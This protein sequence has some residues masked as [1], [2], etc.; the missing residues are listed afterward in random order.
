VKPED[1]RKPHKKALL[2]TALAVLGLAPAALAQQFLFNQAN[3]PTGLSPHQVVAADFNKNGQPDLAV[4]DEADNTVS[5]LLATPSGT[6][7]PK[8]AYATGNGPFAVAT[9]D[10]NG[11]G[12]PD[13]AVTNLFDDT[14]TILLGSASGTFTAG[15]VPAVG[16]EPV[17]VAT[18]D[19]NKD[20]K[21]DLAVVNLGAN[22]VS[23]L[24]GNGDG[25]FQTQTTFATGATPRSVAAGDF[26]G[27]GNLDLAITNSGANS[28]TILL[29][30]GTGS[31]T[32]A[33]SP[34]TASLPSW[35]AVGDFNGDGFLDLAVT[36]EDAAT[37]SV[38]LGNGN[39]TFQA[40]VDNAVGADPTFV[41]VSDFNGDGHLDLA[42]VNDDSNTVSVLLGNGNG[43]FQTH[44]DFG[45]A[46][47]PITLAAADFNGD[48]KLDLAV[49]N[50]LSDTISVLLG[51][52]D[53]TFGERITTGV[54]LGPAA[55]TTGEF[56][57]DQLLDVAVANSSAS[58]I[59][60]LLGN[61]SGGFTTGS[62]PATGAGPTGVASADFNSDGKADLVTANVTG[63][64]VSVLLG[65]GDGTFG[66]HNDF[67]TG[68]GPAAVAY[69]VFTSNGIQD[70]VTA[71]STAK[72]VSVLLGNGDGTF[73]KDTDFT[74][75]STPVAVSVADLNGDGNL[76][77][78]V[79]DFG[80]NQVSILLGTGTG[81]FGTQTTFTTGF[82]PSGIALGD[83]NG[84]GKLDIATAN[85]TSVSILLGN[86]DGTFQ[87]HQDFAAG[88]GDPDCVGSLLQ[89]LNGI[90]VGD[91]NG[92][93]KLDVVVTSNVGNV[94]QGLASVLLG[95]GNGTLQPQVQYSTGIEP[96]AVAAGSFTTTSGL[97]FVTVNQASDSISLFLNDPV[98]ALFP[99]SINFG[100]VNVGSTGGPI[101]V[102]VTNPGDAS[103]TISNV[104]AA[105]PFSQTSNC[106]TTLSPGASCTASVS[107]TPTG[108]G[109]SSGAL[110]LVDTAVTTP[111]AAAL[112]G[113]G[114]GTVPA[115]TLTP[116]SLNFGSVTI[117]TTSPSQ[118]VTLQNTG[119]ATLNITS[120]AA[121]SSY[122]ETST[123]SSTLAAGQSCAISVTFSPL[124]TGTITGAITITDNALNSPQTVGLTGTGTGPIATLSASS[125]N[126][127]TVV[128][129]TTSPSQMV[130][131]TNTGNTKLTISSI[132]L[133]GSAY[134]ETNNCTATLS[135]GSN[136][137]FT[138]TFKP[139]S[140]GTLTGT[141]TITDNASNS[142]QVISMT[143][144]GTEV[145]FSPS[146]LN[147]GTIAVGSSSAPQT[148]TLTNT[149][150]KNGLSITSIG[151]T[152]ANTN[153]FSETNTC[154]SSLPAGGSCT[155]TA[156]FTPLADG[157]LSAS[158]SVTDNGGGSPQ[159][160]PLAGTGSGTAPVIT[161]SP[162]SLNFGNVVV[163]TTS[164]AQTVTVTNS[165]NGA[166]SITSI[167]A[168]TNYGQTNTCGSSLGAGLNCTISV[169]FTPGASGTLNG[170]LTITDNAN[171]SP[172]TV[173]LT[174]VGTQPVVSLS[175]TSLNFG[176][177][178]VGTTSA[179]QTV[180]LT[181]TGNATLN[182]TSLTASASYGETNTCGS[183]VLAGGNCTISV[184]FTPSGSGTITGT[185][186]V[187]DNAPGSPQTVSL[188]GIGTT[189]PAVQLSPAS[190][191]FSNVSVGTTSAAQTV[192]LTNT[193]NATLTITSIVASTN[194]AQAN[195][196]GSSVLAGT[197]C[198][199]SVTFTPP[200]AGTFSGTVT[201]TDNAANSPQ[202]VTLTGT[203]VGGT[204]A[205]SLSPTSL[206]F[207][208]QVIN[209]T[210]SQQTV[211]LT[212]TGTGNLTITSVTISA[213]YV[214]TNKCPI[215]P[216]F[217]A[218]GANCTI[219]A[220]FKPTSSGTKTGTV[221]ITDN[222]AGSPH[223]VSLTGV[224]TVVSFS[225]A[226]LNFGTVTVG[227][228]SAP[229][230]VTLT[231]N[232]SGQALSVTDVALTG[233][234]PGDFSQT[235][236]CSSV[237]AK[238]TCTITVTFTPTATGARS[239]N[240]QV[241]DNGGG[242]PQLVPLSGTGQ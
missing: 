11:D 209:T 48:G 198:T 23:I 19:F 140:V 181:N 116:G 112:T 89:C 206:T 237:P 239:A 227:T 186:S 169:T 122:A 197:N 164:P 192:T 177:V 199:I 92:D 25:T 132:K 165:G 120:I 134:T 95:D 46:D 96:S 202:Q 163:G 176:S 224:G 156:T 135:P 3:F 166:L 152:G 70:L 24:L 37:V 172:Q 61:G 34:A 67:A 85:N 125:L 55:I 121:S 189:A 118:T 14:V 168:G 242:S 39:G 200:S 212:N 44:V 155:I 234:N 225:P 161:V 196:C 62:T 124:Q 226:S 107:F 88:G 94:N 220:A 240:V 59:S 47:F 215:S 101:T 49:A 86:G 126:F 57:S 230:T 20:G 93:G 182:I 50:T 146:S 170:T 238:G 40:H 223:T 74:V 114:G 208:T 78:A 28:V 148:I 84:D 221:S 160:V 60:V 141:V 123:C 158:V 90:A 119:N 105:A 32:T 241:S 179:A 136:C 203:G 159:T 205:V 193:G 190:L 27:D 151:L 211:T 133:A 147:F 53:G 68:T 210:S 38:M 201:L 7:S 145:S 71:N 167:V 231:N 128:L 10:F 191:T 131:L 213:Q 63:N 75:G 83:F 129:G 236:N 1:G 16:T 138:I 184:T 98:I 13:L 64:T 30:T 117:G 106:V 175:P 43:T 102:T 217:V 8:V 194:F 157:A 228:S 15:S 17:A 154:G 26:N 130:T 108:P 144:L 97:D 56:N 76:D 54:G 12:N 52:G 4:A 5:V 72:S 58:T 235:N 162:T 87:K 216:S 42:V 45:T 36:N 91:F 41:W 178:P 229:Q 77:L 139:K 82:A 153:D 22:T 115:V 33:A 80:S 31:F 109:T 111:Q 142:P 113:V 214:L 69:G 35:V 173:S 233:A 73:Q 232:A 51:D 2:L 79:A 66:T 218:P 185:L 18:G 207:A 149:N 104:T 188:T 180:T 137:T 9:A 171:N 65:N 100:T 187:T 110:S 219:L 127:G 174:G 204:P 103:L 21:I 195:T 150:T 222:A 143:G 99:T 6:F 29:G 183:S 81:S